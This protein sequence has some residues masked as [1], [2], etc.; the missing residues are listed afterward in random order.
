MKTGGV[1]SVC[2]MILS[3]LFLIDIAAALLL[4]LSSLCY[5]WILPLLSYKA[6]GIPK[7]SLIIVFNS[8][9]MICCLLNWIIHLC[10]P[11]A[12]WRRCK[13]FTILLVPLYIG[14]TENVESW[15]LGGAPNVSGTR[16][17][18][19]GV[20]GTGPIMAHKGRLNLGPLGMGLN[21][22][23]SFLPKIIHTS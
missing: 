23:L 21:F 22:C 3:Q 20:Y 4:I 8:Y 12:R 16:C 17:K 6:P 2:L 14:E 9:A 7:Q 15:F 10:R 19:L 11:A 1:F 5:I 13:I 18:W